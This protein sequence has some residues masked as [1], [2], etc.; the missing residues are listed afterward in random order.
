[1]ARPG[2][3]FDTAPMRSPVSPAKELL[4]VQPLTSIPRKTTGEP[5][6]VIMLR[7]RL[8]FLTLLVLTACVGC[9]N[10]PH[11][12]V[13][14]VHGQVLLNGKPLSDAIV[15]FHAREGT[16]FDT[17]PTAHTDADGKFSL[18]CYETGD[19]APQ[20]DYTI[21]VVCFRARPLRKGQEGRSEN[22]VPQRY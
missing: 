22:V 7:P 11:A 8:A 21:S 1:R 5:K 16:V 12:R 3:L 20:G 13:Y 18:T 10:Q 2:G 14:P 9:S 4:S 15:S 17:F 19:G 6:S